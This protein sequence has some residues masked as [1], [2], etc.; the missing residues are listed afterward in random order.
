MSNLATLMQPAIMDIAGA[1]ITVGSAFIVSYA[2]KH[3]NLTLNQDLVAQVDAAATVAVS[4]GYARAD[5]AIDNA[6][7]HEQS[8]E[9]KQAAQ[10]V[11][12]TVP[13]QLKKLG[14]TPDQID[15]WVRNLVLAKFGQM[16]SAG[17]AAPIKAA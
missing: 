5:A 3:W 14:V 11:L 4:V 6:A 1:A 2:Q 9:V 7:L 17:A 12:Q 13:D 15:T 16:Q 8:P 10:I